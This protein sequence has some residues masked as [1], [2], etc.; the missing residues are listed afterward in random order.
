MTNQSHDMKF[1]RK[2][3]NPLSFNN[4]K[5][6]W[7][8]QRGCGYSVLGNSPDQ[9]PTIPEIHQTC[10]AEESVDGPTA[11]PGDPR[12]ESPEVIKDRLDNANRYFR[13]KAAEV[14][15]DEGALG[16]LSQVFHPEILVEISDLDTGRSGLALAKLTGAGFCEIGAKVI[17]ITEA[18]Q[19]FVQSLQQEALK[20][21]ETQANEQ[22]A[23]GLNLTNGQLGEL[24]EKLHAA[25]PGELPPEW[26]PRMKNVSHSKSIGL[27]QEVTEDGGIFEMNELGHQLVIRPRS[28]LTMER[29]DYCKAATITTIIWGRVTSVGAG[30]AEFRIEKD[31]IH[32]DHWPEHLNPICTGMPVYLAPTYFHE[33][34]WSEFEKRP[35]ASN[36]A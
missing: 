6:L 22:I 24:I 19:K 1:M 21:E 15:G 26:P 3:P 18:G 23:P 31:G 16:L 34:D 12:E 4:P 29:V 13:R 25:F 10:T 17:Y 14:L 35:R 9:P 7:E 32:G 8:C 30:W 20:T 11:T 33:I 5:S 36:K 27:V 2:L 28:A